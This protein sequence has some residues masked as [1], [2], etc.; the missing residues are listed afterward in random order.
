M[1]NSE[2]TT[3]ATIQ[4]VY[5]NNRAEEGALWFPI[6]YRKVPIHSLQLQNEM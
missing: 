5:V 3:S 2:E 6:E 4:D 1:Q